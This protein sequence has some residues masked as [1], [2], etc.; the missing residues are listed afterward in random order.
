M[1][2]GVIA[3]NTLPEPENIAHTQI[4]AQALLDLFARKI[5]IA[6]AVQKARLG[7]KQRAGAIGID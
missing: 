7:G 1:P 2:V 3:R 6:I 5:R 4:I